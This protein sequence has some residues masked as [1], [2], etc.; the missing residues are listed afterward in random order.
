MSKDVANLTVQIY[1]DVLM[2][3]LAR[4]CAEHVLSLWDRYMPGD[5][6]PYEAL[7]CGNDWENQHSDKPEVKAV[8]PGQF[9]H[10]DAPEGMQYVAGS[11]YQAVSVFGELV[12]GIGDARRAAR[13]VAMRE[14]IAEAG[15]AD[16][17]WVDVPEDVR[18]AALAA[19]DTAYALEEAWQTR[20]AEELAVEMASGW[21]GQ[22]VRQADKLDEPS[23]ARA[24]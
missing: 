12:P 7:E 5:R 8:G 2:R 23:E 21:L 11:V 3:R 14:Y 19:G 10:A 6:R 1:R 13:A 22:L 4:D 18:R 24:S 9:N 17:S 16:A 20:R 15:W